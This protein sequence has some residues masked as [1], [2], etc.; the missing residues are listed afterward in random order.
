VKERRPR[1]GI[2]P[3]KKPWATKNAWRLR[4]L[5][6]VENGIPMSYLELLWIPAVLGWIALIDAGELS[7]LVGRLHDRDRNRPEPLEDVV[8]T[9]PAD[10]PVRRRAVHRDAP[11]WRAHSR[12]QAAS[13]NLGWR[14]AFDASSSPGSLR[15][16]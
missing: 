14:E 9:G 10:A 7:A 5:V 13:L 11:P 1:P 3:S 2:A 12:G 6:A 16:G 15:S 4:D 8:A